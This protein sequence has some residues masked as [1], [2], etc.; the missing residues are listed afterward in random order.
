M[1]D[2]HVN[3]LTKNFLIA[4][5]L[6]LNV[7]PLKQ[8]NATEGLSANIAATNNYLWR[9]LEQTNGAAAISGGVDYNAS[10]GFYVGTWVSNAD[11]AEGMTY[12]LDFYAGFSGEA[13]S[14]T[15]D[16]GFVHYAYPDSVVDVDFTEVNASISF[17]VFTFGYAVLAD[18]KGVDFGD[19]SYISL[20]AEFEILSEAGL[21]FHIG[22]GT[23]DFYA[24]EAFI[25]YGVSLSKGGFTFGFSKTDLGDDIKFVVSYGIDID[26]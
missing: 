20:D 25:D 3:T 16:I 13:K 10:S 11:W 15:Y 12:E 9:G 21:A 14:F 2:L 17:G 6:A 18:A 4:L 24:G 22:S 26:L 7:L 8:A 23:D 5:I 19:D 1:G